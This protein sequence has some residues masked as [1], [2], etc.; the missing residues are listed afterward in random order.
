MADLAIVQ[1]A[2]PLHAKQCKGKSLDI[3]VKIESL[4]MYNVSAALFHPG[5]TGIIVKG[6]SVY[7]FIFL[8]KGVS[9]LI[10]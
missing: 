2:S 1:K 10:E 5:H 8:C 3:L 9:T 7:I 6:H 4:I